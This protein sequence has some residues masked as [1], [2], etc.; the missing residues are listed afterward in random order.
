MIP[1]GFLEVVARDRSLSE[2]ELEVLSLALAG[3]SID[4]IAK[5]LNIR[6][7]AVRKRLGEVYKKFRIPGA[8]PGK[9]AKLQK[10]LVTEYQEHQQVDASIETAKVRNR[11]DWGEAPDVSSFYGR[12][13]ELGM[14]EQWIVGDR[15][16]LVALLGI[17]G[18]GK[19]ALA[20][21]IAKQVKDKFEYVI[22]RSLRHAFPV[23][24]LLGDL[25]QVFEATL[26]TSDDT[27]ELFSQLLDFLQKHRCLLILD[28]LETI[29]QSGELVGQ[30]RQGYEPYGELWR[31]LGETP[32]NS[33]LVVTSQEKPR[34]IAQLEGEVLPVRSLFLT[35]LKE[36]EAREILHAK[37]L[38]GE[39]KWKLLIQLYRGNPLALK[40]VATT[41]G[42]LFNGRVAEFVKQKMLVFG[43]IKDLLEEPFNRLSDLEREIIYWLAI[44][45]KPISL[46]TL[47]S[48]MRLP[49]LMPELLE[50][51]GS[52]GRRSLLETSTEGG[53]SLF[54]LQPVVMEYV[55]NQFVE[56]IVAEIREIIRTSKIEGAKLIKSHAI[57]KSN[58]KFL[59][60]AV[61]NRLRTQIRNEAKIQEALTEVIPIIQKKS[62]LD[63]RYAAV[64]VENLLLELQDVEVSNELLH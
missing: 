18:I 21:R 38:S 34:K 45:R 59:L 50:A 44:S 17:G 48:D 29:L 9:L 28:N 42:E 31:R 47:Q 54:T 39:E 16:R 26:T 32:H 19:T 10:I 25:L 55:S 56:Q 30:Y 27:D 12:Q 3:E 14:L 7:E 61:L 60:T 41:I 43:D 2:T 64:N 37:G 8:G 40:I 6:P 1:Q 35:G 63:T 53:E 46:A 15:C 58:D 23:E 33:C 5:T 62:P 4:A 36:P 49:V 11:L 52:L 20:V 24:E 13:R 22:W 51:L 57:I